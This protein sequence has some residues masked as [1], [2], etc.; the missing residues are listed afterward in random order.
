MFLRVRA[1]TECKKEEVKEE[2]ENCFSVFVREKAEQGK[3]NER[4]LELLSLHLKIPKEKL[5]IVKGRRGKSKIIKA[6]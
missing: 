2:K 4:I 6:Y 1:T 3:A 5:V